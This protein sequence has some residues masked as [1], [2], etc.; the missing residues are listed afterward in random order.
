MLGGRTGEEEGE[1]GGREDEGEEGGREDEEGK[2]ETL[3]EGPL[4]RRRAAISWRKCSRFCWIEAWRALL[5]SVN[6]RCMLPRRAVTEEV[7]SV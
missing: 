4:V 7:M 2:G 6:W 3:E 5:E 1:E